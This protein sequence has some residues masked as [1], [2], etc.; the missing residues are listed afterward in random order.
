MGAAAF[1]A[2]TLAS[3]PPFSAVLSGGTK[4]A[5][6]LLYQQRALFIFC[7]SK[8]KEMARAS[9]AG[10]SLPLLL[11]S[12]DPKAGISPRANQDSAAAHT[13]IPGTKGKPDSWL[14][15]LRGAPRA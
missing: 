6:L 5:L 3:P 10:N 9:C 12:L 8:K 1:P 4:L 7:S 15:S 13:F 14:T 11:V 2:G